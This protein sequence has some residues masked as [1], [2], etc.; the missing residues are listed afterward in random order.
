M[1]MLLFPGIVVIPSFIALCVISGDNLLAQESFRY[2]GSGYVYYGTAAPMD[3]GAINYPLGIGGGGQVFL[4][5]GL[6]AGADFGYYTNPRYRD[7][8]FQLFS[9]NLGY[10]FKSRREFHRI[11]PFVVGGWGLLNEGS[12]VSLGFFGAGLDAWVHRHI[13][14]RFEGRMYASDNCGCGLGTF[15]LG[16]L[17][18]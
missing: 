18:R 2:K 7:V 3:S 12:N 1:R 11:D 17:L 6:A 15:R 10:H 9:T 5:R 13:G 16:L 4:I 14:F 8:D